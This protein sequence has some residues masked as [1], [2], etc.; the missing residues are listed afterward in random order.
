MTG[1]GYLAGGLAGGACPN[2]SIWGGGNAAKVPP[3]DS[4]YALAM[5]KLSL[6]KNAPPPPSGPTSGVVHVFKLP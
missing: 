2:K 3:N 1:I 6:G 5:N 4:P